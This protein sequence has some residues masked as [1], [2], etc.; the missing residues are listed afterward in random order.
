[1][2]I[3]FIKIFVSLILL[4]ELGACAQMLNDKKIE[5]G[6]DVEN[7][8]GLI[9]SQVTIHY[10][11]YSKGLCERGCAYKVGTF[12]GVYMPI[13]PEIIISWKTPDGVDHK[14]VVNTKGKIDPFRKLHSFL[15]RFDG[16]HLNVSLAL[17]P[18]QKGDQRLEDVTIYKN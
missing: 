18:L 1:M 6:F 13:Q 9:I 4:T 11:A 16:G 5:H 8:G 17:E 2:V 10:G 7:R 3:R 14:V 12:Y 15:L